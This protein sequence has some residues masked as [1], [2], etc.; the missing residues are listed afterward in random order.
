MFAQHG[1]Q[2]ESETSV[3][4]KLRTRDQS[5]I[6]PRLECRTVPGPETTVRKIRAPGGLKCAQIF[7]IAEN[8]TDQ[9]RDVIRHEMVAGQLV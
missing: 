6:R 7:L 2:A 9:D 1:L 4:E 3:V 8:E 5:P